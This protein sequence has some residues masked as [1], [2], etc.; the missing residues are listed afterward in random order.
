[1]RDTDWILRSK[2]GETKHATEAGLVLALDTKCRYGFDENLEA[3]FPDG[4]GKVLTGAAL[5]SWWRSRTTQ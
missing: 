3:T 2:S 5:E 4:N 1:M